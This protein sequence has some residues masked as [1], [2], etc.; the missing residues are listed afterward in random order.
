MISISVPYLGAAPEEVEAAVCVRIEEQIQSLEGIKQITS[1]ASEGMGTVM[2]E[3]EPGQDVRELLDDIKS[4]VDA[5]DTF[6]EETEKPVIQEVL[7]R[8]QV[9]SIAVSG[10]ASLKVLKRLAER[11]RDEV[12]TLEG[13][14]QLQLAN[15]RPYEVSIEVSEEALRRWGLTIDQVAQAVRRS[16]LDM[17]GGSLKT[18]GGEVL[19]RTK[20]QAYVGAEFEELVLLTR[21][22][23]TYITLGDVATVVDGFA[24]TDQT[25]RFDGQPAVLVQIFRVGDQSALE[26]AAKVQEYV[27]QARAYMPEGIQ[28]TTWQDDSKVLKSRLELLAR[29]G[30]QGLLLVLLILTLFLRLGLA[31]WVSLG[32]PISFLGTLWLM[33]WLDVS[34]NLMSL[35]AFIVVLGILV[36]DAIVVGEGI[37]SSQRKGL[38]GIEA[39]R[40][41]AQRVAIPVI[42]GVLTTVAAF[43]PLVAVEGS[44]GKIMRVIPLIVIPCLLFSLVE[45][46]LVLPSHLSHYHPQGKRPPGALVRYWQR[47]QGLFADSL[48]WFARRVYR[49][50]LRLAVRLRYLTVAAGLATLLLTA[51]LILGGRIRFVF[52]PEVEADNVAAFLTMPQGTPVEVTEAAIR[53]LEQTAFE[54]ARELERRRQEAGGRRQEEGNRGEVQ[55]SKSKVGQKE[56]GVRNQESGRA[57]S[58]IRNREPEASG[59]VRSSQLA[60]GSTPFFRS[61]FSLLRSPSASYSLSPASSPQPPLGDDRI[62][63]HMLA[64]VGEQPFRTAQSQNAGGGVGESFSGAHLGE[65][66][67]E[68]APSEERA[69]SSTE[70]ANLWRE[71]TGAIPDAVELTFTSSLFSPGEPINIQL[72][73]TDLDRLQQAADQLKAQLARYPGVY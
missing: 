40:K 66:N 44:I 47:F 71:K 16:S 41:G 13:I 5:I 9:I 46:L 32:I 29:N 19:L 17:P 61:P 25:A 62:F 28:L 7:L 69:F 65:I 8:R 12:S 73:A 20:G 22:D 68:L 35:F 15:A 27:R 31:L 49:P 53:R 18:Q 72:S 4:R 11:V 24:E 54:T 23:G 43:S 48:M 3:A 36:D 6:P 50:A 37:Y 58:G 51:G 34:I 30:L 26:I 59:R 14:T 57:E 39:A 64:S 42:F 2:V 45:S 21:R 60:V 56:S 55:S 33:P 38:F 52:L 70:I 1:T 63:R 10:A 67:I